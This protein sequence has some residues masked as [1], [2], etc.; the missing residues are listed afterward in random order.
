V[1]EVG[2]H[3]G[4]DI[5]PRHF[6]S[7]IPNIR[8]LKQSDHWKKAYSMVG[9]P[10]TDEESQVGFLAECCPDELIEKQRQ[11]DVYARA[12]RAN[13]DR[14]FGPVEADFLFCFIATK[15]PAHV[16][17]IGCGVSTAVMLLAAEEAG[18]QPDIHCIDPYP[19]QFLQESHRQGRIRLSVG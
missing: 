10:G 12:C 1:F 17:Q 4:L 14:G 8:E 3:F 11:G 2:Q 13:G 5:L 7:E 19:T 15:R 16:V 18:Y 9:V 6:Y